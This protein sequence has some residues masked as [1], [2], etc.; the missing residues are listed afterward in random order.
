MADP[1]QRYEVAA[2]ACTAPGPVTGKVVRSERLSGCP[3]AS[4]DADEQGLLDLFAGALA[5]GV[6]V[7]DFDDVGAFAG[8]FFVADGVDVELVAGD[9]LGLGPVGGLEVHDREFVSV[10]PADEVDTAG[11]CDAGSDVDLDLLLRMDRSRK[12]ALVL[13]KVPV[14]G[15]DRRSTQG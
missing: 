5:L 10:E 8:E 3:D 11:D 1:A 15:V 6:E 9:V 2:I 14:D 13:P 4:S 7:E 12:F